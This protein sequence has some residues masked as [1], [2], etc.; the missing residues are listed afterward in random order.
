MALKISDVIVGISE[1]DIADITECI[2]NLAKLRENYQQAFG[3]QQLDILKREF[4]A[5]LQRL[6]VLY[7][8]IRVYKG[9]N[10]NYC[11]EELKRI[12]AETMKDLK[13]SF[14]ATTMTDAERL[15]PLDP[16]YQEKLNLIRSVSKVFTKTETL[17]GHFNSV[18]QAIIQSISVAGK[19]KYASDFT[20]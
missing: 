4:I 3:P 12:K 11:E 16:L 1:K 19:D 15:Y 17:Y 10:H 7:S 5:H 20:Q 8:K 13:D 6:G 2:K 9:G 14:R 18:L